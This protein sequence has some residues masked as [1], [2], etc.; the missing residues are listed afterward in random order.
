MKKWTGTGILATLLA[1]LLLAPA[2]LSAEEERS[3]RP[4]RG[5]QQAQEA[6][7]DAQEAQEETEAPAAPQRRAPR[8]ARA[9]AGN[10]SVSVLEATAAANVEDR[11][12]VDAG[13]SFSAGDTV[14]VWMAVQNPDGE[15]QLSVVWKAG[16]TEV[17]TFEIT[18]GQSPRWRTWASNRVGRAGDW[19]VEIQDS[20]GNTLETVSFTVSES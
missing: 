9:D 1:I 14:Y 5:D 17:H 7:E 10:A 11:Q 15:E 3:E 12:A 16:D 8:T 20:S 18:V 13:D 2:T 6:Q 4:T 19:T